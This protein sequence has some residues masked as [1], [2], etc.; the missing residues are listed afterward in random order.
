MRPQI[1]EIFDYLLENQESWEPHCR[2][3]DKRP[4][5]YWLACNKHRYVK[6]SH[7]GMATHDDK[8]VEFLLNFDKKEAEFFN[9][10]IT[11][12]I[13]G[14]LEEEENKKINEIK[15]LIQTPPAEKS[16]P[17]E[18]GFGRKIFR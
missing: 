5:V 4:P 17:P 15:L 7:I 9:A 11:P 2:D 18:K 14:L 6:I 8:G 1:K 13:K 12:I 10:N 16:T 3:W